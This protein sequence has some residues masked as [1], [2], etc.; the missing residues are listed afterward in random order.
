VKPVS[1]LTLCTKKQEINPA[2]A[3]YT[4]NPKVVH[5]ESLNGKGRD[6]KLLSRATDDRIIMPQKFVRRY[7]LKMI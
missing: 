2:I 5:G 3:E 1:S 4:I 7:F 6:K